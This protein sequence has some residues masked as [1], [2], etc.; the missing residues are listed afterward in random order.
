MQKPFAKKSIGSV[1][2]AVILLAF[3][4]CS[5]SSS[6]GGGGGGPK[7]KPVLKPLSLEDRARINEF[8]K[9]RAAFMDVIARVSNQPTPHAQQIS[10]LVRLSGAQVDQNASGDLSLQKC[11]IEVTP[12]DQREELTLPNQGGQQSPGDMKVKTIK[13]SVK[14]PECP[15]VISL[16]VDGKQKDDGFDATMDFSYQAMSDEAKKTYDITQAA[17]RLV[18]K[19][20]M[21]SSSQN[22]I[23]MEMNMAL[24]GSGVSQKH[25]AYEENQDTTVSMSIVVTPGEML[26][27]M[28]MNQT[29]KLYLALADTAVELKGD[30]AVANMLDP[31]TAKAVYVV[32]NEIVD[33]AKYEDI[34]RSLVFPSEPTEGGGGGGQ[35]PQGSYSCMLFAYE[36]MTKDQLDQIIRDGG[37]VQGFPTGF[38]SSC[39]QS[40]KQSFQVPGGER[41]NLA[42]EYNSQYVSGIVQV[43]RDQREIVYDLF[44]QHFRGAEQVGKYGIMLECF[45]VSQCQQ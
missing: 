11:L 38:V 44:D 6:G 37:N 35:Q 12:V 21:Q 24:T 2:L 9:T 34:R 5:D 4:A 22:N 8:G 1:L 30:V 27:L 29:E 20:K 32:N 13:V 23:Q 19:A 25:G 45:K 41:V 33:Q 7:N 15:F 28:S 43:G 36:G 26:P 42:L 18:M 31:N 40:Q 14:G 39:N 3:G 16:I 10:D 17:A